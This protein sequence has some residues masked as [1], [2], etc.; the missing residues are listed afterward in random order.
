MLTGESLPVAKAAGDKVYAGTLN[1][2]G[3]VTCEATASAAARCWP[4]SCAWSREAQGS[5]APIQRLADR[6]AGVFVPV[7]VAIAALTFVATWWLAGDA[8]A[9]LVNAV[10]VLVIACPCALGLATPTAIMVGTGRGAQSGI[11][12]R[13]AAALE[14]AGRLQTLIVDKTGTLTEG[15]PAVTDVIPFGG[16]SRADVLRVGGEPRAG[17]DASAGARRF[18]RRRATRASSRV[19]H[20]RLRVGTGQGRAARASEPTRRRRVLGSLDYLAEQRRRRSSPRSHAAAARRARRSSA[21]QPADACSASSRS[22]TRSGRRRAEA[23]RRLRGRRHRGH[24]A[25]R[26][27]RGDGAS[28][29][30][31]GRHRAS[32][33]RACCRPTRRTRSAR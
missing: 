12:I 17:F 3:L 21:S 5:K 19:A 26:R 9:A 8:H 14:Q 18:S 24:H 11:L 25:D 4:A 2:D 33:A 28:R 7:V 15:R 6:V 31:G 29:R 27:Q 10:A 23:V 16:A 13:N 1:Q 32:F 22:P 20:R 30:R